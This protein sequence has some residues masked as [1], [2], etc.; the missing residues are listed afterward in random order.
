MNELV[1]DLLFIIVYLCV[2]VRWGVCVGWVGWIGFIGQLS[3]QLV[4]V[5]RLLL[6]LVGTVNVFWVFSRGGRVRNW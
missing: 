4:F 3:V 2:F 6:V 1:S 5:S